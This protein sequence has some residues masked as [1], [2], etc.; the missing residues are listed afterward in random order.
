[1]FAAQD[2]IRTGAAV[3]LEAFRHKL[4]SDVSQPDLAAERGGE[5]VQDG[6]P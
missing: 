1:M 4:T 5:D 3:D 2:S 6:E